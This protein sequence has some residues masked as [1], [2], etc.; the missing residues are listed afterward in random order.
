MPR[1]LAAAVLL[2]VFS[3]W[4]ANIKLYLKDGTFNLVREYQVGPD[5]VRYY[6]VERS[7]WE[8]I[9]LEMVD[10]KRTES[11]AAARKAQLD[12]D[13]RSQTEEAAAKR[14]LEKEVSSIPR[15]A[16]VYWLNGREAKA[17]KLASS[18]VRTNKGR[19]VLKVLSPI[20]I[21][22]GKGTLEQDGAHSQNVF[23][24]PEQPFYIQLSDTE[25]FG[26]ARLTVKGA[27][28]VVESLTFIPITKEVEEELNLV[29]IFRQQLGNEDLYKIWPK[30]PLE[31]G[32]YAVV[33]Y[34]AGKLNIQVWDFA[35]ARAK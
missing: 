24:D 8:E 22:T 35:I 26:V 4:A 16:G 28:R 31:P 21:V 19:Q 11:E 18:S 15:D 3:A 9:P 6:S 25:R 32:E 29:D 14:E 17:L 12:A 2:L 20:P 7:E 10:L 13:A 33:Q 30:D 27:V 1:R 5:R 23:T 34:T